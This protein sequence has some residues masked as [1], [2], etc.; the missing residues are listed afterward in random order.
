MLQQL[1]NVAREQA[2][3]VYTLAEFHA[4]RTELETIHPSHAA[5]NLYSVS[6]NFT[7]TAVGMLCDDGA[8]TLDTSV[9]DLFH[10]A[11]PDC[12]EDWKRVSVAQ[13]LTQT[14]G[15]GAGFLDIDSEDIAAYDTDDFLHLVFSAPFVYNPGEKMVY[16]DSNYYLASRIVTAA[17][18]EP[19]QEFLRRRL[20]APLG[21]Q[22]WGWAVCPQGYAMGAT[23]LFARVQDM[24][25]FGRLYLD[26]GVWQGERLLS[27]RWVRE[28]TAA[29]TGL[30]PGQRY[31]YSFWK[32]DDS[33]AYHC[34]GMLGQ[35]IFI[36]P[37]AGRVV[38]WQAYDPDNR[39]GVLIGILY[40]QQS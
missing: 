12:G 19:L 14:V 18:G 5:S 23:G 9:Y 7:A 35:V 2:L 39:A 8:L 13:V 27:E 28:A 6:K 4:G 25:K 15:I 24:V 33:A 20:F 30:G 38:A 32:V 11:R 26:G 34:A 40:G 37:A 16:S 3:P 31:G 1:A 21:F 10:A 29:Y 22:S 17:C 36:D